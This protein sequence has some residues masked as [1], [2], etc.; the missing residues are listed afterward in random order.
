MRSSTPRNN[1]V[2]GK[3]IDTPLGRHYLFD[4]NSGEFIE[5]TEEVRNSIIAVTNDD[6]LEEISIEPT[7]EDVAKIVAD[8]YSQGIISDRHPLQITY[9]LDL[10]AV[11]SLVEN[12][13]EQM[14]LEVTEDCNFRCSYCSFS[15]Q[16]PNYRTH[17]P[18]KM[19]R[20]T[21]IRS[22]EYFSRHTRDA[23][24]HD[25][26]FYGGEPLLEW[27]V[28]KELVGYVAQTVI[29]NCNL[30]VTTNGWFLDNDEIQDFLAQHE[31]S[32]LVS[33]DGPPE[34]HDKHRRTL[35]GQ[36]THEHVVR[37]LNRFRNRHPRYYDTHVGISTV[38]TDPADIPRLR[39]YVADN[40]WINIELSRFGF[41]NTVHRTNRVPLRLPR[42]LTSL[43]DEVFE[44]AK[45]GRYN[46][47][48]ASR[49]ARFAFEMI[50][51]SILRIHRRGLKR[52]PDQVHPG[53]ICIPG[54][55][56][57]F[58]TPDGYF[59]PCERVNQRSIALCLGDLDR[60]LCPEL[61][62][63]LITDFT[64]LAYEDCLK[65]WCLRFCGICFTAADYRA[66]L[67][68]EAKRLSCRAYRFHMH[69]ILKRYLD[70]M[71]ENE[72]AFDFLNEIQIF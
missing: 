56:R 59:Y 6:L 35:G 48:S 55:R 26:T 33:L 2:F 34:V 30:S 20:E 29:P 58:V 64:S 61:I 14:I 53:G 3:T 71:S 1:T 23:H 45:Q 36:P 47:G 31:F 9:P 69:E 70:T 4:V 39:A 66:C 28:I 8:A 67:D 52:I 5:L 72:H 16:Y 15:G 11:R 44:T 63:K 51:N 22:L 40:E 68:A 24:R 12:K 41:K 50:K 7:S 60:G 42:E 10:D 19:S 43:Y 32:V 46:D 13:L 17:S 25:I 21:A 54:V 37:C 62:Y 49:A 18:K 57:V 27:D 65:C 38:I